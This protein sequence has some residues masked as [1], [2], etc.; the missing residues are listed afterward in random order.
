MCDA[1]GDQLQD[2]DR[3]S[4]NIDTIASYDLEDAIALVKHYS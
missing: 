2:T 1:Y 3:E 4:D